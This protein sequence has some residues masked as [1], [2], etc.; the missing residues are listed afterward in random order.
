MIMSALATD[1][2]FWCPPTLASCFS[3]TPIF[4]Q[5]LGGPPLQCACLQSANPSNRR[6]SW[7]HVAANERPQP[8]TFISSLTEEQPAAVWN[9][10]K[11][12][13]QL[14]D[15]M[16]KTKR[17]LNFKKTVVYCSISQKVSLCCGWIS[18]QWDRPNTRWRR[19]TNPFSKSMVKW[20]YLP[21]FEHERFTWTEFKNTFSL[22]YNRGTLCSYSLLWL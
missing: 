4:D 12:L 1:I 6:T 7:D 5:I 21:Q 16:E 14:C 18:W 11:P 13:K 22:G 15:I 17:T 2:S 19:L 3:E 20:P 8:A 9:R 10:L